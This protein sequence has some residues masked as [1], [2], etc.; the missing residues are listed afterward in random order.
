MPRT[1]VLYV[2]VCLFMVPRTIQTSPQQNHNLVGWCSWLSHQSNTLKVGGSSPPPINF[3]F[4]MV[5][6]NVLLS[7]MYITFLLAS[8]VEEGPQIKQIEWIIHLQISDFRQAE[9]KSTHER[10][11]LLL[12]QFRFS[13]TVRSYCLQISFSDST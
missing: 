3:F 13:F 6:P 9:P 11:A 2:I 1:M 7:V 8:K 12:R 5:L 4:L 10:V